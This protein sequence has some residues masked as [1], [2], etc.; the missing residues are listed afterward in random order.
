MNQTLLEIKPCGL[1]S[2]IRDVEVFRYKTLIKIIYYFMPLCLILSDL[3]IVWFTLTL[4]FWCLK[5]KLN[6]PESLAGVAQIQIE[7]VSCFSDLFPYYV[8]RGFKEIRRYPFEE[9]NPACRLTRSGIQMVVMQKIG[10]FDQNWFHF[11]LHVFRYQKSRPAGLVLEFERWRLRGISDLI[12]WLIFGKQ[13][14]HCGR[15][16]RLS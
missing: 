14:W 3:E 16:W 2:R 5:N 1:V 13:R 15:N 9:Y 11:F 6:F 8:K 7:V 12:S 10:K 4:N